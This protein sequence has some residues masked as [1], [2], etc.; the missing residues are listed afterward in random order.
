M[1]VDLFIQSVIVGGFFVGV[2]WVFVMLV[3]SDLRANPAKAKF[4]WPWQGMA[5]F[6]AYIAAV[7]FDPE[8]DEDQ[9]VEQD[10]PGAEWDRD[11]DRFV[12]RQ[13]GVA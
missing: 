7:R 5:Q 12:D 10:D 1:N 9:P 13:M 2:I 4:P 11:H 6:R 8:G 3:R